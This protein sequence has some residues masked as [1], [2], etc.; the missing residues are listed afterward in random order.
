L[1]AAFLELLAWTAPKRVMIFCD[2]CHGST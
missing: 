2:L 1:S